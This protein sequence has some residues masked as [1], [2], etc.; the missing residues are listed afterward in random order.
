MDKKIIILCIILL[1]ASTAFVSAKSDDAIK[2]DSDYE[3]LLIDM[4]WANDNDNLR[5]DSVTITVL[6]DG[7]ENGTITLSKANNWK[8]TTRLILPIYD[9]N[10]NA[11]EYTF[12]QSGADD[13]SLSVVKNRDLD[14]TLTNTY[15]NKT[16]PTTNTTNTT[17]T[18]DNTDNSDTTDTTEDDTVYVG[19]D[20]SSGQATSHE[21]TPKTNNTNNTLEKHKAG[22]PFWIIPL[23]IISIAA[24]VINKKR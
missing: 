17:N 12:K 14:Y 8:D 3:I 4:K 22:N 15:I 24:V 18:T 11:I 21:K 1:I 5:P 13:Y 23:C 7:V 20:S 10:G 6:R 19:G 9:D 2:Q 16:T